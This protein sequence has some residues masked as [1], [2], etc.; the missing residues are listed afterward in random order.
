M[1]TDTQIVNI[2]KLDAET[3]IQIMHECA[4]RLGVVSVDEYCKIMCMKKR[5]VY[6]RIKSGSIKHYS[7]SGHVFPIINI[8]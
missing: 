2:H 6:S 7:I 3:C 1:L 8:T 5:N 4:E